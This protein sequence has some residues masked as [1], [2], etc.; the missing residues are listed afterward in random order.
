MRIER[1]VLFWL[2][3]LVVT[4][5]AMLWLKDVLLPFVVGMIIAYALNPVTERLVRM[6]LS[7]TVASALL[8]AL[9]VVV[10]ALIVTFLVPPLLAQLQQLIETLP[11]TLDRIRAMIEG[12]AKERLGARFEPFKTSLD[13]AIAG[14]QID[15]STVVPGIAK[16]ALSKGAALV[17][18]VSLLLITP[19][20]FRTRSWTP[21]KH[22]PASTA[23]SVA[24]ALLLR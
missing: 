17:N 22:P 2:S 15:W 14:F 23:R 19:G 20:S 24:M 16:A 10:V 6:G 13:Q 9:I 21:Q 8:V 5:L 18:F 3:A 4:V 11:S 7:R 1:Q 12:L